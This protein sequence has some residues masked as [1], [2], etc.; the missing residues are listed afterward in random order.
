[1]PHPSYL[2][3]YHLLVESLLKLSEEDL[4]S[5]VAQDCLKGSAFHEPTSQLT[6]LCYVAVSWLVRRHGSFHSL[7]SLY[8]GRHS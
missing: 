3:H 1:M 6:V 5:F 2:R 8:W 7:A 4:A